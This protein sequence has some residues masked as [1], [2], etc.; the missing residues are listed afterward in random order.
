MAPLYHS[1]D[2]MIE[3]IEPSQRVII[4]DI[5][6]DN[7]TLFRQASGSSHNH[8][9]WVGGYI[10]HVA[11]C[12]NLAIQFYLSLNACRELDFSLSEALVV[13]FLHDIEKPWRYRITETGELE[14]IAGM[15]DKA[16]R[17]LHRDETIARYGL[18]LNKRQL[19]AMR[20]V[21]GELDDYTP[22]QR[23]MW[24]LAAFC[25]LCDV[26][27]ARGWANYPLPSGDPWLGSR[28]ITDNEPREIKI[29]PQ[30]GS[31]VNATKKV[32]GR[33]SDKTYTAKGLFCTNPECVKT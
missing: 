1:I 24:P 11:E 19:N 13:M 8:Q 18:I 27:S 7:Q 15:Q 32:Q 33:L 12:M 10:D 23:M 22:T 31:V 25:H 3:M 4:K 6:T 2:A 30:C 5:Y 9:N 29:C 16:A 28:R 21:E 20:Y 17:A 14:T 26:W